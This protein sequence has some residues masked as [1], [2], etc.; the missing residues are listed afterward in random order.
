MYL[1]T[2]YYIW[3]NYNC[4]TYVPTYICMQIYVFIIILLYSYRHIDVLYIMLCNLYRYTHIKIIFKCPK[5]IEI[6]S[7]YLCTLKKLEVI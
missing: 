2:C 1:Q 6:N 7:F 4:I 5:F 3:R